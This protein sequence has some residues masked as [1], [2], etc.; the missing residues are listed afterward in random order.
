MVSMSEFASAYKRLNPAQ[1]QAVDTIDGPLLVIAGPGTG[2]TQILS[3][4]VANILT[5]TDVSP[6]NILCLTFTESGAQNMRDRLRGLIGDSAYDVAISTYHSFG[7]DII[8]NYSEYFQQ[9]GLE[10]SDDVRLERPVDELTQIQI[11]EHILA[12]LP[13]DS[14]LLS[15]RYYVKSVVSTISDLK[16]HLIT[17][18]KLRE[19]ARNNLSQIADIQPVI[20]DIVN[21]AGGISAIKAQKQ[22]QYEQ[23][24]DRLSSYEGNLVDQ[25][26]VALQK[27]HNKAAELNSPTPLTKWKNEWLHK[28]DQDQF[29]LTDPLRSQKMLELANIYEAYEQALKS[30]AAYD[31][32]DMILRAID[33]L[34]HN[35]ELRYNLQERYQYILLDEF[36]D[37]NPSQFELVKQIAE[38]PVHEGRPNIMAVGDDDQAIFAFQGASVGNMKDFITSFREVAI[39]N[40][41]HNYRSHADILH[42]AHN[43]A[44][45]IEDRLHAQLQDIDKALEAH[46][47]NLPKDAMVSRHEFTAE[48]SEYSWIAQQIT[49]LVSSGADPS[50]IAV[51][52]PKHRLLEG[53]V[54][55]MKQ[56]DIP[57]SYEKRENILETEIVQGLRLAAQLLEALAAKNTALVNQYFPLVLSLP[58]WQIEPEDI[59]KVNWQF[60]SKEE[61]R[62]WAEIAITVPSLK[63]PVMFYLALSST[64]ATEPLEITLDKL[65][66]SLP[67]EQGSFK[68]IAPLKDFYFG[69]AKR[70]T[71]ALKYYEAISHLSVI[72]ARLR[73]Y[74]AASDRQLTLED[75]LDFFVMYEAAEAS[76]VNSHPVAQSKHAVQLMTAYKAKGLEFDHVFILQAHD[77]IWG[78]A[79][80]GGGNKLSLPA[81]LSYIRYTNSTNDERLR[82]FFVALTRARHNLYI[83]SHATK[84]NGKATTPL[85][86]LAET[87]GISAHLPPHAQ[88]IQ[89]QTVEPGQLAQDIETLWQAGQVSL[90]ADFRSLLAD[91][92]KSY[93]MSP[94]HL[95]TFLDVERGGPEAFLVQT[96]LR[97]P[98][99]PSASG[100]YGTA[101]HNSLEWYQNQ[102]NAGKKPATEALL[103]QFDIELKHRY[104]TDT[105]HEHSRSK[106]RQALQKYIAARSDMFARPAKAE[107]NFYNESVMLG[108]AHLSGK[109][110]RLE[111]DEQAKTVGIVDYKTGAPLT[112]WGGSTK[113]FKYMQQLYFYKFLI[114]GSNTWR[115]YTVKEARLEF[116]EPDKI[117]DGTIQPPLTIT[118]DT[119][120]E[121]HLKQLIQVVWNKIQSLDLPDI[122]TYSKDLK[123][124]QAFQK[125][126]LG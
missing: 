100:E 119:N 4:R 47:A 2:K 96:L 125:D 77:D 54:P 123:G 120:E 61:T 110:D 46:A 115:G 81:N 70:T 38:H 74:Q 33:G 18:G 29:V 7:S 86:Y 118:F 19:L 55:F 11:V 45:Q 65:S 5:K 64:A 85:K 80:T 27:A 59:W 21:N 126:L 40:L 68:L 103:K 116:V 102:S 108:E 71:D 10:R 79:S 98:Q 24:L 111:I 69:A 41:T 37:T 105:D 83:T 91:R 52:S 20:D 1:R 60:G 88:T 9:I 13:F 124:I 8:K 32:D 51:L 112:K 23:L 109:I 101:I 17:P 31:F 35:N 67:V 73:D 89:I 82:V 26:T 15:A 22:Q 97:F 104:M 3:V 90:P 16:Q 44:S 76:L 6:S 66:G 62:S 84:D 12:K 42:V 43:V 106:G 107:V 114:E 57:V 92:V 34:K 121:A 78:S 28:N 49:K 39:I 58:Y 117:V 14:P 122:S 94:T 30:R 113:A 72:R 25:A 56:A 36:Q 87:D 99:A 63:D 75:F 48:A 53:L 93:L 50:E 95:N